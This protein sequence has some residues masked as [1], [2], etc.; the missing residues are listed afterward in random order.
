MYLAQRHK[1]SIVEWVRNVADTAHVAAHEIAHALGMRH[2]FG[3]VGGHGNDPT[4]VRYDK[5]G[6][7]CTQVNGLL[8]SYPYSIFTGSSSG[9]ANK[10][11][12]CSKEDFKQYHDMIVR[13]YGSYCLTCGK[14]LH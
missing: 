14:L 7:T 2:D 3:G 6:N 11:T 10:F 12:T 5:N 9:N 4:D 13:R 1:I 8:D